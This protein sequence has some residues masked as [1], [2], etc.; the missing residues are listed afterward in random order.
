MFAT[1]NS[2]QRSD[3]PLFSA[4]PLLA[5]LVTGKTPEEARALGASIP[6]WQIISDPIVYMDHGAQRASHR[7]MFIAIAAV[8]DGQFDLLDGMSS[9]LDFFSDAPIH[10]MRE[11]VLHSQSSILMACAFEAMGHGQFKMLAMLEA[12]ALAEE[13]RLFSLD[14]RGDGGRDGQTILDLRD[15]DREHFLRLLSNAPSLCSAQLLE[16]YAWIFKLTAPHSR[17]NLPNDWLAI[18][19]EAGNS[20]AVMAALSL[21]AKPEPFHVLSAAQRGALDAAASMA[22]LS[23]K[24]PPQRAGSKTTLHAQR[25]AGRDSVDPSRSSVVEAM[26]ESYAHTLEYVAQGATEWRSPYDTSRESTWADYSDN[27]DA[28][29][30]ACLMGLEGAF[31]SLHDDPVALARAKARLA[32]HARAF[33]SLGQPGDETRLTQIEQAHPGAKPLEE[34]LALLARVGS[35]RLADAL[36]QTDQAEGSKFA[37]ALEKYHATAAAS[38]QRPMARH[39]SPERAQSMQTNRDH[40]QAALFACHERESSILDAPA[41]NQFRTYLEKAGLSVAFDRQALEMS[42]PLPAKRNR[43]LKV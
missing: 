2:F 11:S 16:G 29:H 33:C 17:Q 21:G 31:D 25:Q 15:R 10:E 22:L 38:A 41:R 9:R 28:I 24:T 3:R 26:E 40:L 34:E 36:G 4:A 18:A 19:C 27:R 42:S 5:A 30:R 8:I 7:L 35:A 20:E 23:N 6:P 1:K 43:P 12:S 37:L 32:S 14:S 39:H 13:Q